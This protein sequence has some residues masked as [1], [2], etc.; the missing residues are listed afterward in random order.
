MSTAC[1]LVFTG[2]HVFP[3]RAIEWY[4]LRREVARVH[5]NRRLI[6]NTALMTGSS[7]VMRCIGLVFQAWIVGRI[8]AAGIGLYQLVMSVSVLFATFAISGI[9][10][11]TTRLISEEMGLERGA[12]VTGA[13]R[14][15]ACY[16][17]FFGLCAGTMV[18]F[19]AE[20][21][22]FLWIGDART[23]RSLRI[24]SISLPCIALS[25]VMDGYFTA[26]GRVWKPT[27]VHLIE[28]L[29]SIT[30]VMWFLSFAAAGDL[31]QSCAAVTAGGA[32]ADVVSLLLMTAM[33]ALDRRKYRRG[34]DT[35]P[36]LT[37]RMLSVALPLA[38][39]AYART[40]LTTLEHL[41]I[42][43]GLKS[44]GLTA[45]RALAGYGIVHGMALPVVLF[46]SCLL[47][48][49]ADLL[50]P[51]LTTAQVSGRCG[52]IRRLVRALLY[53]CLLFACGTA[54]LL[55]AFS[56][57]LGRLIYHSDDA[58]RYIRLLA[59]LVPVM[60]LDTVTDGC[61]RGLG[62]QTRCMAINVL[63]ATLGVVLVWV[64]LPRFGLAGYIFILYFN[65]CVNF[66]LSFTLLRR[67][68]RRCCADE[69]PPAG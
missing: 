35:V 63:D 62:Q 40:S 67:T 6:V 3:S 66:T 65:E 45:D 28:Q 42:P 41:L 57:P 58:G 1:R 21:V 30:C 23:V 36:H 39:S 55:L 37:R 10:F 61:L 38:V 54:V 32:C 69:K 19:L 47:Y 13:M 9:R 49:L 53:R 34:G 8:G 68:V 50:V 26:S 44:S 43:R 48:A 29:V 17:L 27:L 14:R 46:P 22:G 20:P 15:C 31:E 24:T 7:I 51:E 4:K 33:Y 52:D 25:S 60:Y 11:A 64:L 18:Y 12:G 16:A 59:P 2:R 56:G 5:T